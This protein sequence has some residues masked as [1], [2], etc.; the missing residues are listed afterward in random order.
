MYVRVGAA[1]SCGA[2]AF[3]FLFRFLVLRVISFSFLYAER[4]APL[5]FLDVVVLVSCL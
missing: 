3:F 2:G 5:R 1:F 4:E